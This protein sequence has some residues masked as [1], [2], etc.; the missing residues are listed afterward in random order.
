VVHPYWARSVRRFF[1]AAKPE[2]PPGV[3]V[4]HTLIMARRDTT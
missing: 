3:R 2:Q 4:G 1:S